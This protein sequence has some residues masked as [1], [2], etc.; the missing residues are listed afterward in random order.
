MPASVDQQPI[1]PT[2]LSP[3][4]SSFSSVFMAACRLRLTYACVRRLPAFALFLNN[5]VLRHVVARH[6]T[7]ETELKAEVENVQNE[8]AII[9][10]LKKWRK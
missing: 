6:A 9:M 10:S 7:R 1:F 3:P 4:R 2:F 5:N 8:L